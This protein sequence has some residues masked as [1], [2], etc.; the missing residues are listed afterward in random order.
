TSGDT[1]AKTHRLQHIAVYDK[2]F[3]INQS[4]S[5]CA[6]DLMKKLSKLCLALSFSLFLT[7]A[8]ADSPIT[9]TEISSAYADVAIVQ[10]AKGTA[11]LLNDQLMQYL[12]DEKNPIDVKM[13]IINELNWTPDG[14]N[15]TKTFVDYL[16]KNTRY[17][18]EDAIIKQ[19]PADILLAIAYINASENRHDAKGAMAFAEVALAK[20]N[21]SY[22]VQLVS[23]IIKAQVMFD[24]SW[25]DAFR[26]TDDVRQNAANLT[27]DMRAEASDNVFQY[28]DLYQR[29][30]K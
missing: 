13:A 27:M 9:S 5:F 14:K 23:G 1:S 25:C 4:F 20:N 17:N 2:S 29:Y 3:S 6:S 21:K 18:S 22:T 19:A 24:V 10:V 11:G 8:H 26:A 7:P 12:V 30:C 28:M 16:K 15:N